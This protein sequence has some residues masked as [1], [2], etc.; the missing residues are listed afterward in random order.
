MN[1]FKDKV[2][3]ITGASSGIGEALALQLAARGARLVLSGRNLEAL[4]RVAVHSNLGDRDRLVLPFD[5]ADTTR[6]TGLAAEVMNHFGR[7]DILV[8][9]GGVSQRAEAIDT[10]PEIARQIMEVNYFAAVNLA[11]AVLPY[12]IRQRYG[13]IVVISSIAGKFGFYLRSSY[14][15][16]KHA[17][18]GYFESLRLETEKKGIRI[19]MVCPGKVKTGISIKAMTATGNAHAQ[20]DPSHDSA[21]SADACASEIIKAISHGKQE[22]FI[23]GRETWLIPIRRFLPG[24]F[25]RLIRRQKPL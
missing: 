8:N 7:I 21:M 6:A 19:L 1:G 10:A 20:M 15:A 12:M 18:H 16:A 3:W 22:V 2:I 5:L 13:E 25:N 24:L 4:Q 23:G 9:N 14:S 11:Q 17:L